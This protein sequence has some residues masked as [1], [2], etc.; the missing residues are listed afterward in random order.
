V[1]HIN[2]AI[3][4]THGAAIDTNFKIQSQEVFGYVDYNIPEIGI[5]SRKSHKN[6]VLM[7]AYKTE[8][9]ISEE[10]VGALT[11]NTLNLSPLVSDTQSLDEDIKRIMPESDGIILFENEKFT[12][13]EKDLS[14][15][16]MH[17]S[18]TIG[19][20]SFFEALR[21]CEEHFNRRF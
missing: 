5:T 13:V 16:V 21:I 7:I 4:G 12:K 6:E 8:E 20:T 1:V 3:S 9:T 15:H 18:S 2:A 11:K 10:S 19:L 14:R 17:G